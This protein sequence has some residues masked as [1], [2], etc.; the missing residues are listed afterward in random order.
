[1]NDIDPGR[2]ARLIEEQEEEA[3]S[4]RTFTKDE[5]MTAVNAGADLITG[6][7]DIYLSEQDGDLINLIV[8]AIGSMLDE[9]PPASLD[10]VIERNY[11]DDDEGCAVCGGD[12]KLSD[13]YPEAGYLHDGYEPEDGH[14]PVLLKDTAA[15]VRGWVNGES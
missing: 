11:A 4:E 13:Q 2:L 10:E 1:M 5:V 7:K 14:Q 9:N 3:N 6:D 8:N 15:I 12:L